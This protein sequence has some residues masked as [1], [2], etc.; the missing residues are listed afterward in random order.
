LAYSGWQWGGIVV[1]QGE[2]VRTRSGVGVRWAT[3]IEE[4][5]SISVEIGEG[6]HKHAGDSTQT[7]CLMRAASEEVETRA[8]TQLKKPAMYA[9]GVAGETIRAAEHNRK[10][11]R[12]QGR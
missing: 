6:E 1:E 5:H 2:G 9:L 3:G 4:V 10:N 7:A 11:H 12:E 8:V